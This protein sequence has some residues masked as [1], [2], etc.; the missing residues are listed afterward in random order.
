MS[1]G[2]IY[3]LGVLA[4]L[5]TPFMSEGTILDDL[6][7]DNGGFID[8]CRK[9]MCS[10]V[11]SVFILVEKDFIVVMWYFSQKVMAL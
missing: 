7:E 4:C 8:V 9:Q 5:T 1:A 6:L 11:A 2:T 3:F 10:L